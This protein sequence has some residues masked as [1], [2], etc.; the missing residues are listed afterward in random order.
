MADQ[1][2]IAIAAVR[3]AASALNQALAAAHEAGLKVELSTLEVQGMS[4]RHP[5]L[6]VAGHCRLIAYEINEPF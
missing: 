2:D 6:I 5:R 4:D 1:Q 3:H